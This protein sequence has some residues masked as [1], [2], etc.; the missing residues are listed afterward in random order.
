MPEAP[1]GAL[2]PSILERLTGEPRK[3]PRRTGRTMTEI[4][5]DVARS[6]MW[7]LNT[8][9]HVPAAWNRFEEARASVLTYGVPDFSTSSWSSREDREELARAFQ[10]AIRKF[11]PR[12]VSRTV[13]V[14][15]HESDD[16]EH[17]SIRFEIRAWLQVDPLP[18]EEVVF[19]SDL[20]V[21]SGNIDVRM[22]L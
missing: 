18:S 19:D 21:L 8:R 16:I 5:Q 4:K 2:R 11:E 1:I 13:D 15:V 9:I 22:A 7:L 10:S 12:L 17:F 14:E 6:L 20:D 3:R